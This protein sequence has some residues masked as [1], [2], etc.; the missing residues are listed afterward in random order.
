[1]KRRGLA[2]GG[3]LAVLC[4]LGVTVG[5]SVPVV[6]AQAATAQIEANT[7]RSESRQFKAGDSLEKLT[8][9]AGIGKVEAARL[10]VA[11]GRAFDLRDLQPG[12]TLTLKIGSDENGKPTL[13]GATLVVDDGQAVVVTQD[14]KGLF[15][16]RKGSA[17][18]ARAADVKPAV[19]E[20]APVKQVVADKGMEPAADKAA[21]RKSAKVA[22]KAPKPR[23]K[24]AEFAKRDANKNE[25]NPTDGAKAKPVA[26]ETEVKV[27]ASA[28]A[29]AKERTAPA[30]PDAD[31]LKIKKGDTLANVLARRGIPKDEAVSAIEAMKA[32]IDLRSLQIGQEVAVADVPSGKQKSLERLA[33]RKRDG[34][35]AEIE[36]RADG[37]FGAPEAKSAKLAMAPEPAMA[38]PVRAEE[39]EPSLKSSDKLIAAAEPAPEEKPAD[40]TKVRAVKAPI[41]PAKPRMAREPEKRTVA[42]A[43]AADPVTTSAEIDLAGEERTVE[44]AR[45]AA[46]ARVA[47]DDTAAT[48]E[49]KVKL[50]KGGTLHSLLKAKGYQGSEVVA[51]ARALALAVDPTSLRWGQELKLAYAEGSKGVKTL[52]RLALVPP[53]GR[54]VVIG[55]QR[56]GSYAVVDD[57]APP[58]AAEETAL[59]RV[60]SDELDIG[61]DEDLAAAND[62]SVY[63][64]EQ[65]APRD[66]AYRLSVEPGDSLMAMLL[67]EGVD[68]EEIDRAVRALRKLYNPRRLHEGQTVAV[69][70]DNDAAGELHLSAFT[71]PLGE[72]QVIEVLRQRDGSYK[73]SQLRKPSFASRLPP[74]GVFAT[75]GGVPRN[76]LGN[77]GLAALGANQRAS[78]QSQTV[79]VSYDAPEDDEDGWS[80]MS[81]L[82][83][84]GE[85]IGRT[86]EA[87]AAIV[88]FAPEPKRNRALDFEERPEEIDP[89]ETM[90]TEEDLY[91][92]VELEKG[93]TITTALARAG[94]TQDE[95]QPALLALK[96]VHSPK[97]LQAGQKISIS[98][99]AIQIPG[100]AETSVKGDTVNVKL[101]RIS[102]S[103]SPDR[104]VV[105]ERSKGDS[106]RAREIERPLI[107]AVYRASGEIRSSFY[108]S[109]LAAGLSMDILT[110][111]VRMFSYDVDFQRS[112]RDGDTFEVLYERTENDRGDSVEQATVLFAALSVS[113][114]R[115]ELFRYEPPSGSADYYDRAGQSAKKALLRTPIDGARISSGFGMRKHPIMGFTKKHK[116]VDFAAPHG[117][118]VFA[119]GDGVIEKIGWFSSYGKY[120]RIT[121][122]GTYKTAYAHLRGYARGMKVGTRVRQGQVIGYVGSTGRSTGPHLHYEV[123]KDDV[124]INP[125]SS[126]SPI[127]K[128]LAGKQLAQF[129][130]EIKSYEAMYAQAESRTK[131]A[132]GEAER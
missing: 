112:L 87:E 107:R 102:I 4:L 85:A 53:S 12:N 2:L 14:S 18:A 66:T 115:L 94:V 1:M 50:A 55:R 100:I 113:G 9:S 84:I 96:L 33:I 118:P 70:L 99:Q 130:S 43:R 122:S 91:R 64:E 110:Q 68:A 30:L 67:R 132:R 92:E 106:F 105:V 101:D 116:G 65:A 73:A 127:G 24:P 121:H 89:V 108:D 32:V 35:F 81:W 90:P 82:G 61:P 72:R 125:N 93:E 60:E 7:E 131:V 34:S 111:M 31:L 6:T 44:R 128:Q 76:T 37:S 8:L 79:L 19:E 27:V 104:D 103:V 39:P 69:L 71:V 38:E 10:A 25:A 117:T 109:A 52:E 75:V 5:T 21:D 3:T 57:A 49:E 74:E 80:V 16:A 126:K 95:A 23:A 42:D 129:K 54:S 98:F 47:R 48:K 123:L 11:V 40:K 51:A 15:V 86:G 28:Q 13:L 22:L 114:E 120:I 46:D 62:P 58:S 45:A 83:G 17:K 88:D 78:T 56:D 63:I 77:A 20:K 26:G 29:E 119:G 59:A 36:R 41:P 124:Q 97:R